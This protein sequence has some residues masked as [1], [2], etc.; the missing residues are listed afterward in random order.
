MEFKLEKS[1]IVRVPPL[2]QRHE[3]RVKNRLEGG[4]LLALSLSK[5]LALSLSKG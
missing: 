4:F 5:G 3:S 2:E 1:L